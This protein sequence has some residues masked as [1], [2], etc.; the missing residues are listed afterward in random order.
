MLIH[1]VLNY[2]TILN[3]RILV[4]PNLVQ[5]L[6]GQI[7]FKPSPPCLV[8][9]TQ[10]LATWLPSC[11]ARPDDLQEIHLVLEFHR[12]DGA[13]YVEWIDME[14]GDEHIWLI[15]LDIPMWMIYLFET[16]E[17]SIAMDGYG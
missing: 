3:A 10:F 15:Y 17:M 9:L 13:T 4:W 6:F 16:I 8:G 1:F 12:A 5:T 2:I 11:V 14:N 7:L